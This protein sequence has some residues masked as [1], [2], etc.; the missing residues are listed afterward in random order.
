MDE[1]QKID[2]RVGVIEITKG[3]YFTAGRKFGW[4]SDGL[5]VCGVGINSSYIEN[6]D[7]LMIRVQGKLYTVTSDEV[8][9]FIQKYNS[10]I[11]MP[12]G[13]LIGVISKSILEEVI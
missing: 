9:A 6:A 7:K 8:R 1:V 11:R 5:D 2:R 10:F 3:W 13:S 12:G 4:I